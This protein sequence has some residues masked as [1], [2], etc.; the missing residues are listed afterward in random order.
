MRSNLIIHIIDTLARG[1]AEILLQNSIKNLPEY[2]HV[3]LYLKEPEDLKDSFGTEV[4]L[5]CIEHFRWKM[6][7]KSIL[8]I[9][10]IIVQKKPLLVHSHLFHSNILARFATPFNIPLVSSLHSMYSLDAFQKN[11]LSLFLERLSVKRMHSLIAVSQFVL[12]DYLKYVNFKGRKFVHYNFLPDDFFNVYNSGILSRELKCLAIGNLKEAKNY[13]YLLEIFNQLKDKNITLDIIGDGPQ[14]KEL[15]KFINEEKLKVKILGKIENI[16]P[17]FKNYNLFIQASTHE[18]FGL[19]VIE[20]MASGVP[21]LLSDIPVFREITNGLAHFFQIDNAEKAAE[22]I[23]DLL[24]NES[25]LNKYKDEA[26]DYCKN[27][28]N[29]ETHKKELIKIYNQII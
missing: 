11:K 13:K 4:E 26:F 14:K 12:D 1:G 29:V 25:E 10:K 15:E 7:L 8:K 28:Y 2:K 9:R 5:I 24:E 22:I 3:V 17:L 16:Q 6:I 19:S 27:K 18:G 23:N 20:A 21:V